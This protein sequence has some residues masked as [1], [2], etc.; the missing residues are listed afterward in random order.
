MSDSVSPPAPAGPFAPAIDVHVHLMPDRLMAAIRKALAQQA[1]WTFPHPTDRETIEANLR[2]AGVERY[3][4]LPY[5]HRPGIARDLN[6]WVLARTEESSM[7][8]PFAT[9]HGEDEVGSVVEDAFAADARGLKFQCPVQECS[10]ADPRLDPAFERA[11]THDRAI[12][13]HAGTAPMFED[14]PHVGPDL[15]EQFLESYP[16]VRAACAHMGT[17]DHEAFVDLVREYD[18]AFLDTSV[19]SRPRRRTTRRWPSIPN[20][21]RTRSS[22]SYPRASCTVRITPTFPT[23]TVMKG[24]ACWDGTS[25]RRPTGISSS[26]PPN[27]SSANGSG[28]GPQLFTI[29]G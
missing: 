9:V 7:A 25:R 26:G 24:R 27:D 21:Y 8:V 23:S 13:F 5:A 16:D 4:A 2:A 3:V 14:S 1:D 11:A 18:N 6:D 15:F 28:R 22:R 20:R 19:A 29:R 17:Y 12:L 10:P